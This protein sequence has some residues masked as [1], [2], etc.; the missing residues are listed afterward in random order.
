MLDFSVEELSETPETPR[1]RRPDG[2]LSTIK[3]LKQLHHLPPDILWR[4]LRR[5]LDAVEYI[6][7]RDAYRPDTTKGFVQKRVER[8]RKQAERREQAMAA[9]MNEIN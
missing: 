3:L 4:Q 8:L 1:K 6:K 9:V 7:L 5:D 2:Y